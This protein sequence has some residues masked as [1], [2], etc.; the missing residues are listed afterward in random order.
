MIDFLSVIITLANMVQLIYIIILAYFI[1]G[2]IGF[3]FINRKKDPLSARKSWIKF[4]TYFIIIHILFF[5]IIINP[6]AFRFLAGIIIIAGFYE[7]FN[8]HK[9]S[10]FIKKRFFL[11]S[12]LIFAV[13]AYSFFIFSGMD[14]YY[15]LF[16]FLVVS[17]FDSFSQITGQIFGRNKLCLR[18]SPAKTFEG[19]AGGLLIAV[20]SSLLFRDLIMK[21][22]GDTLI[23]ASGIVLFAFL[24]D[25]AAS[26]YKRSFDVKDFSNVIPGH[27]GFLDRFDSLIAGGAWIAVSSLLLKI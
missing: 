13:L 15:I 4:I 27:G 2:A 21:S 12:A 3:Y 20:F 17:V 6:V 14:K 8:L 5:S 25:L 16:V 11:L 10:G 7:I 26:Y 24:G 18:I 19:M 22:V 1:L 23:I 9:E